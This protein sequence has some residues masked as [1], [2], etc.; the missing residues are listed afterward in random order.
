[1]RFRT[2]AVLAA[3]PLTALCAPAFAQ[4]A[5]QDP[6]IEMGDTA[7]SGDFLSVG[8]GVAISPSYT[9]SDDYVFNVLPIIQ[10]SLGGIGISPRAGGL[11]LD[12]VDRSIGDVGI[13]AG[14]SA[15]IRRNR[16]GQLK[17]DVVAQYAELETAI[18]VGP[19]LG[20]SFPAVLN[21]FDSLT[22]KTD[23]LF[24]VAGA[25]DGL[26]VNPS[27]T[28]FTPLNRGMAASFSVSAEWADEDFEDYYFRVDPINYIAPGPSPLP[29][30]EPD[31]GGFTN[32]GATLLLAFDLDG[33]LTNGGL[34]LIVIGGYSR[35][36]GDAADTPFTSIRGSKDQFLG[37][38]GVGYT[39]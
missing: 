3:I 27:V 29:A 18:E 5:P 26:S 1:M 24:D 9:G 22:V 37:A 7:F 33:D 21:P 11:S 39:F 16:A 13:I 8:V 38:V 2:R 28:Y 36:L 6:P 23:V 32:A 20:L 25:H 35:V 10:G 17:D 12:F 4:E 34:G 30:F 31:G 15:R 14:V 19:S